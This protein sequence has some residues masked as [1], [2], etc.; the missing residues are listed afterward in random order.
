LTACAAG[1]C[2]EDIGV[3][4][5]TTFVVQRI[6]AVVL[7]IALLTVVAV[8]TPPGVKPANAQVN[9][10]VSDDFGGVIDSNVWQVH[11]EPGDPANEDF[12]VRASD[13][14]AVIS[15]PE[16][17]VHN[18]W[19]GTANTAPRLRQQGPFGDTFGVEAKFDSILN[20]PYQIQ[21]IVVE[22]DDDSFLRFE[23]HYGPGAADAEGPGVNIYIVE[24]DGADTT[25]HQEFR[26]TAS[27]TSHYVQVLRNSGSGW[28]MRWSADGQSWTDIDVQSDITPNYV[29]PYIGNI[30]EGGNEAP[31]F[32]GAIDYFENLAA[33]LASHDDVD[34]TAPAIGPASV[35]MI[36]DNSGTW[37]QTAR[38]NWTT[39]EPATTW[40]K[41]GFGKNERQLTHG[42]THIIHGKRQHSI[43]IGPLN[44]GATYGYLLKAN[45]PLGNSNK[46]GIQR[47]TTPA[48]PQ[49][50]FSDKFDGASLD[51][52]WYVR[53]EVGDG[54]VSV[55]AGLLTMAVPED[56]RHRTSATED[57]TLR[58]LQ[59]LPDRNYLQVEVEFDSPP[60]WAGQRHGLV[61]ERSEL[62]LLA[63]DLVYN[64]EGG[65]TAE[66]WRRQR[67]MSDKWVALDTLAL[68]ERAAYPLR[69]RVTRQAQKVGS[70]WRWKFEVRAANQ[71]NWTTV[72]SPLIGFP[73]ARA[74]LT[75][76]NAKGSALGTP[77]FES[78]VSYFRIN[79]D[80][81]KTP[82]A[83]SVEGGPTFTIFDGNGSWTEGGTP[84]LQFTQPG[85]AQP[86]IN[87]RGRV[88]DPQGIRSLTYTIN[89]QYSRSIA[90]GTTTCPEPEPGELPGISCTRRLA[91]DGDFNADIPASRLVDGRNTVA[92]RAIDTDG[93]L[94]T[95]DV[96][97]DYANIPDEN[98]STW[99][100][101]YTADWSTVSD[102]SSIA[103]IIDGNWLLD[104]DSGR[105]RVEELGYDRLLAIGDNNWSAY[106]VEV[107]I[108][109]HEVDEINSRRKP[110]GTAGIGL[111]PHWQGH[112]AGD[113]I[114]PKWGFLDQLGAI[115][116]YRYP[117][118]ANGNRC[119]RAHNFQLRSSS[120][121]TADCV[122]QTM[123]LGVPYIF[124]LQTHPSPTDASVQVYRFKA[125]PQGTPEPQEWM[126]AG[127]WADGP[128]SGSLLLVAH[129]MKASFGTVQATPLATSDWAD[130][131]DEAGTVVVEGLDG[132]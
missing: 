126:L 67:S 59:A 111:I 82:E 114:Q 89:N 40:I 124:K 5:N 109:I 84:T 55:D 70:D 42:N 48:C 97:V 41:W 91:F 66:L 22:E 58:L 119:I 38:L 108:E 127:S 80:W 75:V 95:I 10:I 98:R 51:A 7:T 13:T 90:I 47:L 118:S 1:F 46:S 3:R 68:P 88:T 63:F 85:L 113:F 34:Q 54:E 16:G 117:A 21:G 129:H 52:G 25:T 86:D 106:E 29:G 6:S 71:K 61:F 35:E 96:F 20:R 27:S 49:K 92:F 130:L 62:D 64:E 125:W 56:S 72:S 44:C 11:P 14:H 87:V 32:I 132:I 50:G 33:P 23:I 78:T 15:V 120:N 116:W 39:D 57:S 43:V 17:T 73:V 28:T 93:N 105:L 19:T 110:S 128:Q 121:G 104:T 101:P 123:Q 100:L 37:T 24:V 9:A 99:P 8:T 77:A 2:A 115:A 103:Q 112:I 26:R 30:K 18:L 102:V 83:R 131:A 122:N 79:G 4:A 53:D 60:T 76:G 81:F 74:G 69:V 107:P 12:I 36:R 45:D 94:S 31:A 65:V